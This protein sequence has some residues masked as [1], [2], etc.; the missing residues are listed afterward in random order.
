MQIIT[1][2]KEYW[3]ECGNAITG[4]FKLINS[5]IIFSGKNSIVF[6]L[7]MLQ[8]ITVLFL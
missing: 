8:L 1:D 7:M 2:S 3:D 6:F 5:K 4:K